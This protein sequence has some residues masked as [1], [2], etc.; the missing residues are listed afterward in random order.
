ML[1]LEACFNTLKP[2]IEMKAFPFE[3]KNILKC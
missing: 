3:F 2:L 1:P